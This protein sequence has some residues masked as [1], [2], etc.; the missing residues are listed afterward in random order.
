[1]SAGWVSRCRPLRAGAIAILMLVLASAVASAQGMS[2][3]ARVAF[4]RGV[5]AGQQGAWDIAIRH[6]T[7][8]LK[9]APASPQILFSLGV[10][11]QSAGHAVPAAVFLRAYLDS[12]PHAAN[13]DQVRQE[14]LRLEVV[15]EQAARGLIDDAL[16]VT[17]QLA[18]EARPDNY[19]AIARELLIAG[20]SERAAA[21]ARE[22]AVGMTRIAAEA[23]LEAQRRGAGE[24]AWKIFDLAEA[25]APLEADAV[26]ALVGW[27]WPGFA[28]VGALAQAKGEGPAPKFHSPS[29]AGLIPKDHPCVEQAFGVHGD[30]REWKFWVARPDGDFDLDVKKLL[31]CRDSVDEKW[32]TEF[33]RRRLLV[34]GGLLASL[35]WLLRDAGFHARAYKTWV[36]AQDLVKQA[37]YGRLTNGDSF[38]SALLSPVLFGPPAGPG[39]TTT[40]T[41]G[42]GQLITGLTF[43]T[44]RGVVVFDRSRR[45]EPAED[46]PQPPKFWLT[47]ARV[48]GIEL[49]P[50]QL[51]DLDDPLF[52]DLPGA[53]HLLKQ[54]P[55]EE[56]PTRLAE[57]AGK[58][59]H[60]K[61]L[62][63]RS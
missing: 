31:V 44:N 19:R 56:V 37:A 29:L 54:R 8:A 46:R 12:A 18:A 48:Y 3:A 34:H 38:V 16:K 59:L 61:N 30:R 50:R 25:H 53:L 23:A 43:H 49:G 15:I 33:S 62:L 10:A 55:V 45:D 2:P 21:I 40:T 9:L 39:F 26:V 20:E 58:L 35:G 57:L 5:A 13:A 41:W 47:A 60:V 14:G 24:T 32:K 27:E 17:Q 36:R 22:A 7:E 4:E 1:M 51:I 28:R 6:F 52:V 11:H 42:Q 63:Q